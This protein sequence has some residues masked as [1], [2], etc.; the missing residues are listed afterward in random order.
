MNNVPNA[1]SVLLSL[2]SEKVAAMTLSDTVLEFVRAVARASLRL[3]PSPHARP[4]RSGRLNTGDL[5]AAVVFHTK[6]RSSQDLRLPPAFALHEGIAFGEF[7]MLFSAIDIVLIN[8]QRSRYRARRRR[9]R[10]L[11]HLYPD[12]VTGHLTSDAKES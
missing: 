1:L 6:K 3:S 5:F 7:N 2:G 9:I 11:K 12:K 10:R 4:L 8:C